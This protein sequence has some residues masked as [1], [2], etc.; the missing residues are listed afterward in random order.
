VPALDC[1][2]R[3]AV[4]RGAFTINMRN[5]I[6]HGSR[7]RLVTATL[8]ADSIPQFRRKGCRA[9][10]PPPEMASTLAQGRRQVSIAANEPLSTTPEARRHASRPAATTRALPS[11]TA[12]HHLPPTRRRAR[13]SEL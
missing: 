5:R 13:S 2:E 10:P 11:N 1:E 7:A 9:C 3:R 12:K 4:S 8:R 6:H